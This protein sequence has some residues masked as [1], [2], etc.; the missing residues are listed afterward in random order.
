MTNPQP[1]TKPQLVAAAVS[2]TLLGL[3]GILWP[4]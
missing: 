1:L 2:L 4:W 3:L